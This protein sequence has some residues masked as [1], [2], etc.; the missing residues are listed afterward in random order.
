MY[1]AKRNFRIG[2]P[3]EKETE[4]KRG[5]SYSTVPIG[6]EHEF[7]YYPDEKKSVE[8]NEQKVETASFKKPKKRRRK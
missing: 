8:I 1:V 7:N 5:W 2:N 3:G 6:T 4:F